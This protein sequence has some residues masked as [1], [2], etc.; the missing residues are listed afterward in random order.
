VLVLREIPPRVRKLIAGPTVYICDECIK[1]CNDILAQEA[2]RTDVV[3]DEDASRPKRQGEANESSQ[4]LCC[5]FCGK[6]QREVKRLI[7]GPLAYICDECIGLCND[8]IFE[9]IERDDCVHALRARLPEGARALI[10]G[11]LE[12]GVTSVVRIQHVLPDRITEEFARRRA[13]GEPPDQRM[14][15]PWDLAAEWRDLH[16]ILARAAPEES[17]SG[18]AGSLVA[19]LPG[20][21]SPIAERLGGTLGVLGTLAGSLEDVGLEEVRHQLGASIGIAGEKL[22]EAR[23]LLLAGPPR[24][25][26]G[27]P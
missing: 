5:S 6:N 18:A 24:I 26:G 9:E 4:T 17:A 20:W 23:E 11:I 25:P 15:A 7:A 22:R 3:P 19:E 1:L 27:A 21:V 14:W 8:I 10:A 12:R 2:E 16:E 13:A